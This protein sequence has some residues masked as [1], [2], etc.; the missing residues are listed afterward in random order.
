MKIKRIVAMLLIASMM[1]SANAYAAPRDRDD[2]DDEEEK[3]IVIRNEKDY[4]VDEEEVELTVTGRV[5]KIT[6]T[7]NG[8]DAEIEVAKRGFVKEIVLNAEAEVSGEGKVGVVYV[9]ADE[10]EIDVPGAKV[11]VGAN[12]EDV[13]AGDVELKPGDVVIINPN[14]EGVK[15]VKPEPEKPEVSEDKLA[16]QAKIVDLGWSKFVAVRFAKGQNLSN[17]TLTVDGVKINDACTPVTDDGSVVK[18]EV[19]SP[20]HGQLVLTSGDKT[21]TVKLE[22]GRASCRERV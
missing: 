19:T 6:V 4:T 9:N 10:A 18:W 22:I 21:Q 7:E 20:N 17:T 5:N 8:E 3:E 12:A 15:P 16:E 11:V 2:D 13:E 1:M 14:G